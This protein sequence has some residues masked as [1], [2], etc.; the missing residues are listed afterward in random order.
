MTGN[1]TKYRTTTPDSTHLKRPP[2][3]ASPAPPAPAQQWHPRRP[4]AP[5]FPLRRRHNHKLLG[6]SAARRSSWNTEASRQAGW[7]E[8]EDEWEGSR[9]SPRLRV[10][11]ALL[12]AVV[13]AA[14]C[15]DCML[16]AARAAEGRRP[17]G[18][19][20]AASAARNLSHYLFSWFTR[21]PAPEIYRARPP[22]FPEL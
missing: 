2:R 20:L 21:A 16:C 11:G 5:R 6:Q 18:V 7:I 13:A 10:G 14:A 3:R 12:F 1:A 8:E 19:A 22:A 15:A 9:L 17:V 4:P